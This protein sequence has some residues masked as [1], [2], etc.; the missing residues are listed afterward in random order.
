MR[1]E[2]RRMLLLLLAA[3]LLVGS[4]LPTVSVAQP[5]YPIRP[6]TLICPWAAGGGTD[7]ISR[8]VAVLLEKELGVPVTVVNRTG[9]GGAVGHTAGA[10]ATPDGYTIT[11]VTVEIA[12]M[13]WLG[14]AKVNYK[15]FRP[16]ALLNYDPAGISVSA[17]APWKT[18]RELH[19]YIRANPGK[20]KASGTAAGGIWD[21]ARAGWL[22]TAGFPI[23]A[24]RWIPST[25]AAPALAELVAGGVDIVTASLPEA[26]PLIAAGKVRP[27]AI[28]A[29][30]RDPMFPDVPTLKELGINWSLGAW[31]GIAVPKFTTTTAVTVLEKALA[32]VVENP[33]FKEFMRKNGFGILYKP[34][35]EFGKFMEE[36]DR[37]MGQLMKEVGLAK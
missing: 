22:K 32:K 17:T 20:L 10:T 4:L 5:K 18:Y 19:E 9:G 29:E 15:D 7:R 8:M 34:A 3:T 23:D 35:K 13:H 6:I 26:A 37:L 12:M 2:G 31:R 24:V 1:W 27:L 33:E 30:K 25:G 36:Q 16:V 28:M 14:L 11:M 21:L